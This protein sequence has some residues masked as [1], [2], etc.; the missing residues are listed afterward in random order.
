M[1]VWF[2]VPVDISPPPCSFLVISKYFRVRHI[3]KTVA[4]SPLVSFLPS[5]HVLVAF[6]GSTAITMYS[7]V[8]T[9]TM[10]STTPCSPSPSPSPPCF[11]STSCSPS[12][13]CAHFF[14]FFAPFQRHFCCENTL[15][16]LA[17]HV[18][19]GAVCLLT[20]ATVIFLKV[21]F[22][23]YHYLR[24]HS[25]SLAHTQTQ[26]REFLSSLVQLWRGRTAEKMA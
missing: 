15:A 26:E 7:E 2:T 19:V 23:V 22:L 24:I 16:Q 8:R 3:A 20:C 25:H 12:T 5:P 4:S 10:A 1:C 14:F 17:M 6:A 11:P 13:S 9:V 21:R 18:A